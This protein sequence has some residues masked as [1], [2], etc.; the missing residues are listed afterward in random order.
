MT[1]PSKRFPAS[2]QATA[3]PAGSTPMPAR[4]RLTTLYQGHRLT[5][6]LSLAKE[7]CQQYPEC[8]FAWKAL[9]S[10]QLETGSARDAIVSLEKAQQLNHQDPE[11]PNS[12]AKCAHKLGQPD[13]AIRHL[14]QALELNPRFEQAQ[15][16][17]TKFLVDTANYQEAVKELDR[18]LQLKPNDTTLMSRK[19]HALAKSGRFQEGLQLNEFI[20]RQKPKDSAT[21]SNLGSMYR[22]VNRFEEAEAAFLKAHQLAPERLEIYSNYLMAMHYN[23][24]HS[25]DDIAKA[26]LLWDDKYRPG[27]PKRTIAQDRTPGRR[28]RIGM[29]SAGFR[30]HPVG[31]M[32]TSAMESLERAQFELFAYTMSDQVDS[33]TERMMARVDHWQSVT[34][35]DNHEL[36]QRIR[37]D[38]IDILFD[39]CGHTEGNRLLTIASE[40]APLQIKWVGGQINTTGLSAMDYMLSDHVETPPG[41]DHQY[42]EKL[43]R[44][45]DDY[46]CY[47]PR[48]DAPEIGVLPAYRNGYVTFGC[49]NNP[50]KVNDVV[51][52]HWANILSRVPQSRLLLKGSQ[53][54]SQ[55]FTARIVATFSRYGI[56]QERILFEGHS[57][58]HH[59]LNTYNKVDIALDPWPYS[60]GLTTCEALLMGVPVITY[61]GPTFAGRHSAT[62]L[63]NAGLQ[64]LVV[65]NWDR[66]EALAVEL[67]TD[68]DNLSTI[69]RHL[70]QQLES[71][72]VCDRKR[73]ARHFTIA[74][75]AIWQRYCEGKAPAALSID[76][77]GQAW[78]EGEQQP[79]QLQ[80][81][82][83]KS[84]HQEEAFQFNFEGKVI[85]LDHGGLLVGDKVFADLQALNAF[86]TIAFDPRGALENI[87]SLQNNGELHHYPHVALGN[88]KEG[89]LY[90]CL[91]TAMTSTLL[92]C[93]PEQQLPEHQQGAQVIAK[94]PIVTLRLDDI[95][96]LDS[97]DWLLLDNLSDSLSILENG[98]KTLAATLLVQ[99][100]VNFVATH[101]QQPE[102]TQISHWLSRHG[103]NFY[104]L[105]NLQHRSQLGKHADLLKSQ[106]TQL[107]SADALFI[108]DQNRL[109][110]LPANQ[111]MKLA[112]ILHTVYGMHD[113]VSALLHS[114]DEELERSY[115]IAE[116]FL[117]A[118][119]GMPAT[120]AEHVHAP[121][122]IPADTASSSS[123]ELPKAPHM[124]EAERALFKKALSE[125][126]SY[127]EF[128][129][130][131]S[132]VWAVRAGLTVKGVE[133]DASWVNALKQQLG[134]HCQVEAVDIG[135]TREWGYP[136]SSEHSH[137]FANYSHAIKAHDYPFDLILVDGR[138]RVA[139]TATTIQHILD[140]HRSP[141][142][143]RIFIHDFW[144]RPAYHLVLDFLDTLERVDTAGVFKLKPGIKRADVEQMLKQYVLQPA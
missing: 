66:Y 51:I 135:P 107:V 24:R 28:L 114:L 132:T 16:M 131:G 3:L 8:S 32:I 23:P 74:M 48:G 85:T 21:L 46:I 111:R 95:E 109:A 42:T 6:A 127:F 22:S 14:R 133:S 75:R 13:E 70:R 39:L 83:A 56:S 69:R 140:H 144:D 58:H 129:S 101:K 47:M 55:D 99:A 92:P 65:D 98:E 97:I 89:T 96:G 62:H 125:A 30:V 86:A 76:A 25:A 105:H 103:F 136:I 57:L 52:E 4:E 104:R 87:E 12:L 120:P 63:T 90:A 77:E 113:L 19:A 50:S 45:P 138:F 73:F 36:A 41:V 60:G 79:V 40:P 142:D 17:L 2:R 64:E 121:T 100:R 112:F 59:L 44:L 29:I 33:L 139:C 1:K 67:A 61:P 10:T 119:Q 35:L 102:L 49:F 143:A 126:K 43:I 108:P 15:I 38:R 130:G 71:S 137:K 118:P 20:L 81:D 84:E 115:L 110:Q 18:A 68:L 82:A 117:T 91:D 34:H 122:D 116:K 37:D 94:L 88:G 54:D 72:P 78:F 27:N 123:F 80:L 7:L 9:G 124:S 134:E 106:A 128:G 141:E 11:I 31:Q 93:P 26:H 5:E 53:Y